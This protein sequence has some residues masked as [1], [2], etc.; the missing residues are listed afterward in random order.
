MNESD[1]TEDEAIHS[2]LLCLKCRQSGHIVDEC[3]S[4]AWH[5]E[6]DWFL[7]ERR[8]DN[9]VVKASTTP[10]EKLCT[11]C[12]A[13]GLINLLHKEIQWTSSSILDKAYRQGNLCLP[14]LGNVG[15]IRYWKNCP[16][17]RCLFAMTPDP[18]SP[19]Q[20]IHILTQWT[21]NR[22]TGGCSVEMNT[23]EKRQS[24]KCLLV[25]LNPSIYPLAFSE[26]AHRGDALCL[27]TDNK[28]GGTTGLGG[29]EI[30]SCQ[31]NT[32]IIESWISVCSQRHRKSCHPV[33]TEELSAIRHIDVGTRTIVKYPGNDSDYIALATSGAASSKEAFSWD[34][35]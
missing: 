20:N 25:I 23:E 14:S 34:L 19:K 29:R 35:T 27:L 11:R 18:R 9:D 28:P 32:K 7:S 10:H 5:L 13:L 6:F 3:S 24:T 4:N 8:R 15:F 33:W 16:L 26:R 2:L 22:L 1:F 12:Q 17:C 30:D 21:M 31:L